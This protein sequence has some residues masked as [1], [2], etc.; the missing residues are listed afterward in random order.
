MCLEATYFVYR[1]ENYQQVFGTAMGSPVSVTVANLIMED[2]EERA[3]ATFHTP[4]RFW[5]R[6]VDDVCVAMKWNHISQFLDH[7]NAIEQSIEF[8]AEME[9]D[10]NTLPY[11]DICLYHTM[12]DTIHTSVYRKPSHTDK[13]QDYTSHHPVHHKNGVV[14]ALFTRAEWLYSTPRKLSAEMMHLSKV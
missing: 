12:E 1:G 9:H 6:N 14:K 13:Y 11:M 10:D 2:V 7:L 4:H 5:K 3:P 8:T